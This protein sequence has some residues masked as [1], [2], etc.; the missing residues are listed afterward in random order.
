MSIYSINTIVLPTR[1]QPDTL[2]AIYI[3]KTYGES[4]FPGVSNSPV[5]VWQKMPEGESGDSLL[6]KGNLLI[7]LGGGQ[8][9][10]HM[11]TPK[12]TASKLISTYLAV[13]SEPSLAKL[14]EYAE[15]DDFFG[16][17]TVSTDALD[18]AFGL[19]GLIAALN[20]KYI[21][22]AEKITSLV[23]PFIEAH[24]DEEKRRT[25]ELPKEFDKAKKEGHVEEML[26]KQ[27][28]KKLKVVLI[29][30]DH[31]GLP[32]FLRSQMGGAYDVVV[33]KLLTGHV[34][35]LTRPTK[36]IDLRS[37]VVEIRKEELIYSPYLFMGEE[38]ELSV[39]GR[40]DEV[41]EWYYD[42][43][44]N[45][46]QNGGVD[47]KDIGATKI[48]KEQWERILEEGLSEKNWK[49]FIKTRQ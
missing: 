39:S 7:D 45:S 6:D 24:H 3:L 33:Q 47:P 9:D 28:D 23:L 32:G 21:G 18:R 29:E 15:R 14:L 42:P 34:N 8:F 37:L 36:K 13:E 43:A 16:K 10:H 30:S 19:S 22:D 4:A 48:T 2:V 20:K 35:I 27:R 49:P 46:V 1:P 12:T 40:I 44:T 38:R 5:V 11:K 31:R 25:D 17:G 26:V 41:P